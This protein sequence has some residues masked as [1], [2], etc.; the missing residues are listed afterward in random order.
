MLNS[1]LIDLPVSCETPI[2]IDAIYQ[3]YHLKINKEEN[4][5]AIIIFYKYSFNLLYLQSN[6]AKKLCPCG[7]IGRRARF[8]IWFRKECWFDSS[9]GYKKSSD[10]SVRA[11]YFYFNSVYFISMIEKVRVNQACENTLQF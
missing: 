3:R 2:I 6:F 4:D 1:R 11:F 10:V 9:R 7:G 8:K 5:Y